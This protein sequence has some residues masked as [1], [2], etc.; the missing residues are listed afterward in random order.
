MPAIFG[1]S[2]SDGLTPVR[3]TFN[4]SN[5][6]M[7][8]DQVSTATIVDGWPH[9]DPNGQPVAKGI[10]SIDGITVRPW[11]VNPSTGGVLIDS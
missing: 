4:T 7:S 5:G 9:V 6:G 2:A 10:D 11:Y 1:I 8:V 3:I